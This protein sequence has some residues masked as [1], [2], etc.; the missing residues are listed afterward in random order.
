MAE[1]CSASGIRLP[2]GR[3]CR[4]RGSHGLRP[5][6]RPEGTSSNRCAT[7]SATTIAPEGSTTIP[8]AGE[9][10]SIASCRLEPAH[11]AL[12]RPCRTLVLEAHHDPLPDRRPAHA[13][14]ARS[15]VALAQRAGVDHPLDARLAARPRDQAP[16]IRGLQRS[17]SRV[18]KREATLIESELAPDDSPG[19]ED[20]H[21]G[22]RHRHAALPRAGDAHP[23][24]DGVEVVLGQRQGFP[25]P[26]ARADKADTSAR[27]RLPV[28][29]LPDAG[30][31]SRAT[32]SAP[33]AGMWPESQSPFRQRAITLG[34]TAP[35]GRADRPKAHVSGQFIR[36]GP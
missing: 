22:G 1:G 17:P 5:M 14:E 35:D 29:P 26:E 27:L 3:I 13:E 11:M 31:T 4:H 33:S 23:L 10:S 25:D 16:D 36:R 19:L 32:S 7:A 8:P 12:G 20:P 30:R 15:R 34:Q 28:R 6:R 24:R 9:A 2:S 18:R 21:H